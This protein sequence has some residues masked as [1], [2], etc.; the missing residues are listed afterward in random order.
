VPRILTEA[1]IRNLKS[2]PP[3]KRY[4]L[5]D[6]MVPGLKLRVTQHGTKTFVLWR[7]LHPSDASAS[8]LALGQVGELTLADARA[9][10]RRWLELIKSGVDPRHE[11]RV[12]TFAKVMEDYLERHVK[13]K[14]KAADVE[15]E[16]RSELLTRW[17][18]KPI[19]KI[20]R[21]DVIAMVDEIKDRGAPYQARNMLGHAKVFFNWC[22][23]RS[24]L[25]ASPC[26]HISRQRIIGPTPPRQRMLSNDEV[27]AFW[28][29]T[30]QLGY[31]SGPMLRMLLLT[32]QRKA[33]VSE[34]QWS[35]FD[36]AN[37]I[38]TIP[39]ERF[40]SDATHLVP[41]SDTVM[42]LLEELPRWNGGDFLFSTTGGRRP[43]RNGSEVKQKLDLLMGNPPPW[44][45]HDLRRVVRS[46]LAALRV[47]DHIA[48]TVIGHG[49]KG[50]AR[51]YDQHRYV[52]EMREALQGWAD[53]LR[54]I[55]S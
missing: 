49:R 34:A 41:L 12:D 31:P 10:A 7:R 40:K 37:K 43:A 3:G 15:R 22:V 18:S 32:G 35:E 30:G 29:A 19:N 25:P 13:G 51:V 23:E 21:R 1:F 2:A 42:A 36:L 45:I 39:K 24:I 52:E 5:A 38:W 14:R 17:K 6:A 48:E 16:M 46:Q 8:A 28:N 33:E 26:D 55:V 4:V 53:R 54:G 50:I 20:T 44:V 27:R 11:Q 47:Q 9:K